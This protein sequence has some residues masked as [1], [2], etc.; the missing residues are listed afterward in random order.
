MKFLPFLFFAVT[1]LVACEKDNDAP[2]IDFGPN[3][4]ITVRDVSN[5]PTGATDPTDWTLDGTW[6]QQEQDLF[7]DLGLDLNAPANGTVSRLSFYP[8]P[9]TVQAAFQYEAP[10]AVTCSF[11]VV[12]AN[13]QAVLN[14]ST[15]TTASTGQTV[16]LDVSGSNF[17]QGRLYRL[18]YVMRN[19]SALYYKGHGDLKVGM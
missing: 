18:Y 6:N 12:D 8:N 11:V 9:A 15:S 17:Q 19:G 3:G 14:R 16:L 5:R 1:A 10:V 4:G 2:T 13:Y 7:K